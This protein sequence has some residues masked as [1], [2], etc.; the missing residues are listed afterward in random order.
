MIV[1]TRV[2]KSDGG[3]LFLYLRPLSRAHPTNNGYTAGVKAPL[4]MPNHLCLT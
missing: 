4:A 3:A 1:L 2:P